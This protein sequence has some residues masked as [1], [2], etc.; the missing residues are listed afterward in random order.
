MIQLHV[1]VKPGTNPSVQ[2]L[3]QQFLK[4]TADSTENILTSTIF[5]CF[6]F[7]PAKVAFFTS[8]RR[9]NGRKTKFGPRKI[10]NQPNASIMPLKYSPLENNPLNHIPLKNIPSLKTEALM[11]SV[12]VIRK[13]LMWQQVCTPHCS[14]TDVFFVNCSSSFLLKL[15]KLSF[16]DFSI[17]FWFFFSFHIFVCT[18]HA[19]NILSEG[20][21]RRFWVHWW[22]KVDSDSVVKKMAK[23]RENWRKKKRKL[24]KMM[25][26][27]KIRKMMKHDK[28]QTKKW[29]FICTNYKTNAWTLF[30]INLFFF[31]RN[32][33]EIFFSLFI[34]SVFSQ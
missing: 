6:F 33:T 29:Y 21:S 27:M 32:H 18:F 22:N 31:S 25:K 4:A 2:L 1:P 26:L 5:R 8:F 28:I 16:F 23:N 12:V 10:S 30:L 14:S 19:K 7:R 9:Q 17:F 20:Q 3:E 11:R 34:K 15:Q 13:L 24:T